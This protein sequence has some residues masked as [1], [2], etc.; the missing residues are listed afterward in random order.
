[1]SAKQKRGVIDKATNFLSNTRNLIMAI[2]T[3]VIA[4]AG[5]VAAILA[6]VSGGTPPPIPEPEARF[7]GVRAYP[8]VGLNQFV[9]RSEEGEAPARPATPVKTGAIVYRLLADTAGT[10]TSPHGSVGARIEHGTGASRAQVVAVLDALPTSSQS[11][12]GTRPGE[13]S[14]QGGETGTQTGTTP[15]PSTAT[16]TATTTSA[17]TTTGPTTTGVA[18]SATQTTEPLIYDQAPTTTSTE[19][20]ARTTSAGTRT[21]TAAT[22]PGPEIVI[23]DSCRI[24]FC[25][26][27]EEID[28]ALTDSPDA[29][30]AAAAVAELFRDSRAEI[31]DHKLYPVGMAVA[32]SLKLIGWAHRRATLKWSLWSEGQNQALP[33]PWWRNITV[34]QITPTSNQEPLN[35]EF[36]VPIP[37]NH[38][39]YFIHLKL[40]DAKGK[41]RADSD[42]LPLVH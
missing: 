37:P 7:S 27:T 12:H 41:A 22:R 13:A 31:L 20:A 3:L 19:T 40:Y 15:A 10:S 11:T 25:G 2:A 38:G 16:E 34:A 42:S 17:V 5:A 8:D 36:W 24:A 1:M 9:V 28:K 23:P 21:P 14:T 33:R 26:A 18:P 30:T 4:V 32:Y 6:L 29:A 35:G 39:N